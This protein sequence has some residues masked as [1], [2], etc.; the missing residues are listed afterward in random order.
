MNSYEITFEADKDCNRPYFI[1]INTSD[2]S[3]F[4]E[5]KDYLLNLSSQYEQAQAEKL[6]KKYEGE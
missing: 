4:Q 1:S 2:C 3:F 5:A 6:A